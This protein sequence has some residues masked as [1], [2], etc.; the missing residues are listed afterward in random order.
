MAWVLS[1]SSLLNWLWCLKDGMINLAS[2]KLLHEE[3]LVCL[4]LVSP[5]SVT[6]RI[7]NPCQL[8]VGD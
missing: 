6:P 2:Q 3:A 4:N 7:L 8:L 5:V 1:V